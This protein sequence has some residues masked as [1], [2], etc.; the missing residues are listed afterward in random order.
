M[1]LV[2]GHENIVELLLDQDA[3]VNLTGGRYDCALQAASAKGHENIVQLLLDKDADVNLTGGRYGCALQ[4]AS[5]C[6]HENIAQLL[7]D[8]DAASISQAEDMVA[9]FKRH[10]FKVMRI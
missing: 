1:A 2:K 8:K 6:G 9:L 10:H 3:D 4:A 5:A 7:L